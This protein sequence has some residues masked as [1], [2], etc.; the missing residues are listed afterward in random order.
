MLQ[1]RLSLTKL[2]ASNVRIDDQERCNHHRHCAGF[3]LCAEH[4]PR[5]ALGATRLGRLS[6]ARTRNYTRKKPVSNIRRLPLVQNVSPNSRA[7]VRVPRGKTY[8][9]FHIICRG[10]LN[11]AL[12]SNIKVKINGSDRM[13]WKTS[14]QLQA[15]NNYFQPVTD[16]QR[17]TIDY[18]NKDA[19][20]YEAMTIG[21]LA[22]TEEAGVDDCVIEFDIGTYTPAAG[23][24]IVVYAEEDLPSANKLIRRQRNYQKVLSG[25]VEE[26]IIF[27]FGKNGEQVERMYVFG[28]LANI[29]S[30][31][32]RR[33]GQELFEEI[34]VA[35]NEFMQ[36]MFGKNPQAGLMVVD[37]LMNNIT[38]D[39]L[40][41]ALVIGGDGKARPV[42]NL[43]IRL[44]T[45]AAGTFEIYTESIAP[46]T[47]A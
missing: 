7:T 47:Q 46:N 4:D 8:N 38:S 21:A 26:Q 18:I 24:E 17:I 28:T 43:D 25:A 2:G 9:R 33:D 16:A 1:L 44:L 3:D 32:I 5:K 39:A 31:R 19:K 6:K 20:S 10:A 40:N 45:S 35:D 13:W 29:T 34:R 30:M 42:E 36:R 12:L 22:A 37:F 23:T 27:P 14:A 41:T 15:R 11:V